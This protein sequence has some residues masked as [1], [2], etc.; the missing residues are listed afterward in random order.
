MTSSNLATVRRSDLNCQNDDSNPISDHLAA[1]FD[2]MNVK[3]FVH[4]PA[5]ENRLLDVLACS[6]DCLIRDVT[7]DDAGNV[8]EHCLITARF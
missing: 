3:E 4:G 7:I 6:N 2:P 5:R 1:V 8:S